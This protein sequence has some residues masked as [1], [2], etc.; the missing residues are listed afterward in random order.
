[1]PGGEVGVQGQ[2]RTTRQQELSTA[3]LQ[4]EPLHLLKVQTNCTLRLLG[5]S[6]SKQSPKHLILFIFNY[7]RHF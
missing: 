2:G 1:M 4:N 3:A 6:I 5:N 7:H